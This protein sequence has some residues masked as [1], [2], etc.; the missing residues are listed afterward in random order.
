MKCLILAGG[1][2]DR[3]WPLSRKS[4]PKQ[5]IKLQRNHSIFQETVA[6]NLPFCD[7][8]II[9]T[10]TEY[11]FII[12][13]QMQAFPGTPYRYILEEEGRKTTA[14]ILLACLEMQP[15]DTIF[16]VASDHIISGEQYK[17]CILRAKELARQDCL[18]TI[19]MPVQKPDTQFGYIRYKGEKVL[20]FVEK[21]D[22]RTARRYMQSGDYLINSGMFLFRNEVFLREISTYAADIFYECKGQ[23]KK[24]GAHKGN[25]IYSKAQLDQITPAPVEKTVFEH[26]RKAAV[27]HGE[28]AWKDIGNF[29]DLYATE[30]GAEDVGDKL[31]YQCEDVNVINQCQD[32]LVVADNLKN[33]TIVNTKDAVYVGEAGNYENLKKMINSDD[34]TDRYVETGVLTYR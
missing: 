24:R 9:S 27:V 31:L 21:P 2:G 3:L 26:T 7:E 14:S 28:F 23:F 5:F 20:E 34:R 29:D 12:E 22:E 10:S 25:I 11:Q 1:K 18:V 33:I 19:G 32:T 13:N 30:S 16:V 8:F 4:Y 17:E 15:S 6:R